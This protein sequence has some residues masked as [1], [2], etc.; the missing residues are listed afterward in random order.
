MPLNILIVGAGAIGAFYA[1]R[2]AL[3]A[4]TSVSVICRSNYKAVKANGFQ[5][6]SPQY[7]DYTFTPA[8]TF[9]NPEEARQSQIQWDYIVVS[10]KALPDV[11]DDSAILEGLVS[12]KTAIVLIQNGLGVEDPYAKRFP[13]AA[14][15]SAV[16][17]ATCAQP[18]HGQIKHNRWT[19]INSGPYLPHLDT[20]GTSDTDSRVIEKNNTFIALL[21]EGGIKD[22][23][24]YTHAKLQL[25]R[26]HKIA[27]NASMNPT[28]VFILC[29]PNNLMSQ[30]PE[31]QRHLKGVMTEILETAPKILGQPMPKDFAS[32]DQIIRSTLKNTSGSKPSMAIDW[33][34]GKRMEIEVILGNPLRIARERGYEMPRLQSLYAMVRMAQEI[35]DQNKGKLVAII[36][37]SPHLGQQEHQLQQRWLQSQELPIQQYPIVQMRDGSFRPQMMSAPLHPTQNE[38]AQLQQQRQERQQQQLIHNIAPRQMQQQQRQWQQQ[39][40]Q[41]QPPNIGAPGELQQYPMSHSPNNLLYHEYRHQQQQQQQQQSNRHQ[42]NQQ[43]GEL[44]SQIHRSPPS[45]TG[46]ETPLTILH[47]STPTVQST[48]N[49]GSPISPP[50]TTT[51]GSLNSAI[52]ISGQVNEL[53]S[54]LYATAVSRIPISDRL[55]RAYY[56]HDN[57]PY[58]RLENS[59]PDPI[60]PLHNEAQLRQLADDLA[61]TKQEAERDEKERVQEAI[62][63]AEAARA[64]EVAR[65]AQAAHD[66]QVARAV[67]AARVAQAATIERERIK[68]RIEELRKDSSSNYR[69]LL[70]KNE[71]IP[72]KESE[73]PDKY[74]M[75]LLANREM[76]LD[77]DSELALAI[78][79]AKD[80]WEDYAEWPRDVERYA[81]YERARR[82]ERMA[83]NLA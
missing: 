72:L 42:I 77:K 28:S 79:F 59:I 37:I 78:M 11:S 8:N 13:Q 3:V 60:P 68:R 80:Y 9:A 74:L 30:D 81:G 33:E 48:S 36:E 31:V 14:I 17:I 67:E 27:I 49:Q 26:W 75:M 54:R 19:R 5:V 38:I 18:E 29:S 73:T 12:D 53:R 71:L 21:K 50:G 82:A 45:S 20:G 43:V 25:V 64:A 15:C 57:H 52:N 65:A 16:T 46:R 58:G 70:E 32:P 62:R 55:L 34:A 69:H 4:G 63:A 61:L 76:P 23:E 39:R 51:Q 47:T 24:A 66:A 6:T 35:R 44:M 40:Q 56:R 2:L 41:Q 22:A 7:G 1:S 10:T 83:G